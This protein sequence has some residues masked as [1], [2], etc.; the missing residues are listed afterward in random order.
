MIENEIKEPYYQPGIYA[1]T[2]N[3]ND[4]L[5]WNI[6]NSSSTGRTR[7]TELKRLQYINEYIVNS[8]EDCIY[9]LYHDM[10]CPTEINYK[11]YPRLHFH[12]IL[13][14]PNKEYV[15][16]FLMKNIFM[17]SRKCQVKLQI[18]K[19]RKNLNHWQDYCTKYK[20]V[21]NYTPLIN[22]SPGLKVFYVDQLAQLPDDQL[23]QRVTGAD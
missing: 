17:L 15:K 20:D 9:H 16:K 2:L 22:P 12:G 18:I 4:D 7:N 3:P 5:Q 19:D 11:S 13:I 6:S 1:I 8:L 14:L 21:F 23:S 10:S